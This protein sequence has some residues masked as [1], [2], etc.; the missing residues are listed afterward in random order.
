MNEEKTTRLWEDYQNG[1]KYQ[2]E[3]G[4]TTKLPT[5]VRF[6]EGD[7]WPPP[8]KNTKNLPRPVVNIINIECDK[9]TNE[10]KINL[11]IKL[12]TL[13]VRFFIKSILKTIKINRI[14][15][16]IRGKKRRNESSV[17]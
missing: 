8:T 16:K 12:K 13:W 15:G 10:I 7:Q 3:M 6:F 11:F 9:Q 2:N 1:L 4:L 17:F 14:R 5:F